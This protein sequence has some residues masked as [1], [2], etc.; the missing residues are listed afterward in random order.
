M[1]VKICLI[2]Y[3]YW[4][5]NLLRIL[6]E[7]SHSIDVCVAEISEIKRNQL[8]SLYPNLAVYPS[9]EV[10]LE[11]EL[12][13]AVVVASET[14]NHY[15]LV[16]KALF[17]G[18]HVLVEKPITTSLVEAEELV[19]IAS[20]NSLVLMV[21]HIFLYNPVVRRMKE[22]FTDN[23]LGKINYIDAT[24]INLGI[25]Q[26]DTNV[27]W[28]LACHDISIVNY[29]IEEKPVSVR[30]IGRIN[31]E[32]KVEDIAYMFLYYSSGT[33]VQINSSWAS[34]VKIRKMIIGGEKRMI[35]YDDIEPTNK[36]VIYEY[37][38]DI[39]LDEN[40][41]ELS[42]YRLGNI[43][44]PK[45]EIQEPLKNVI[46]EFCNSLLHKQKPLAGGQ[47]AL[48]VV[49]ILEKAQESLNSGGA[50]ISLI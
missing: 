2:G 20:R 43:I 44:I 36:L 40:K 12:I 16:K 41:N 7:H 32:H 3:G 9:L 10:V 35:I 6:M 25:Y 30:A 15:D 47:N 24:R 29:L 33:L 28:D 11:R 31:P 42:D 39:V 17:A 8:R 21:D 22:Y 45:Y 19:T 4:G 27:L 50:I 34:P 48:E 13:Q 38:Q 46:T 37:A 5:K 1:P 18:K 23:F 14:G 26:K 49:Q